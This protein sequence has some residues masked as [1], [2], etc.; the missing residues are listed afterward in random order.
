MHEAG[1]AQQVIDVCSA[2]LRARGGRHAR[3]YEW[4][5]WIAAQRSHDIPGEVA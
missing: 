3:M 5:R 1:L 2:E 4:H